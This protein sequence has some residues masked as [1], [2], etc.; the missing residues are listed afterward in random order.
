ML[1]LPAEETY[2]VP[3]DATARPPP[4]LEH[5][6]SEP[7]KLGSYPG[8]LGEVGMNFRAKTENFPSMSALMI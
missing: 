5:Q 4:T 3:S 6:F 2:T 1:L 7:G 8:H